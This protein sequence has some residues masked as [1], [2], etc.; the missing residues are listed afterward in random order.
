MSKTR[1]KYWRSIDELENTAAFQ[2]ETGREFPPEAAEELDPV[3]RAGD[4]SKSWVRRW[5]W[6]EWPAARASLPSPSIHM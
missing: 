6:P 4:F 1:S 5:R 2:A 3:S